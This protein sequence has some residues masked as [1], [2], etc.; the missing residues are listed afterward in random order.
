MALREELSAVLAPSMVF[1][2]RSVPNPAHARMAI[3]SHYYIYAKGFRR[4]H[5]CY[6]GRSQTN[7]IAEYTPI[8]V[9]VAVASLGSSPSHLHV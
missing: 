1:A 9:I 6:S 7:T 3:Q 5:E 8:D 2:G 4:W